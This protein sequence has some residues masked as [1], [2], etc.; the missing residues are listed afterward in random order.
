M[1]T[2]PTVAI[3]FVLFW[4]MRLGIDSHMDFNEAHE[5]VVRLANQVIQE[6]NAHVE[7]TFAFVPDYRFSDNQCVFAG[8]LETRKQY[9]LLDTQVH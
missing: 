2:I 3:N 6:H 9:E 1:N 5:A 7:K 4:M 8:F